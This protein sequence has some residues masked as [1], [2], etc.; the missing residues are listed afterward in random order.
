[1]QKRVTDP[2]L[3]VEH[4]GLYLVS[5][6]DAAGNDIALRMLSRLLRR[7]QASIHLL[8]NERVVLCELV[9]LAIPHDIYARVSHVPHHIF[10]LRQKKS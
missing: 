8:L 6:S 7:K 1:M 4:I 9:H 2:G 3:A 10:R 5:H